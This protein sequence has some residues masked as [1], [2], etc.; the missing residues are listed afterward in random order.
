M[1]Q[2]LASLERATE[3]WSR[4]PTPVR[5]LLGRHTANLCDPIRT[6]LISTA[7]PSNPSI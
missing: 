7:A 4:P 6:E 5:N 3:V 2:A 1:A